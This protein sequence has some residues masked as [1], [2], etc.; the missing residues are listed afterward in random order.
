MKMNS[1]PSAILLPAQ[2]LPN[3]PWIKFAQAPHQRK[4]TGMLKPNQAACEPPYCQKE[5]RAA[6]VFSRHA[7]GLTHVCLERRARSRDR[8]IGFRGMKPELDGESWTS[9]GTVPMLALKS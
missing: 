1:E 3:R 4:E 2:L 6:L 5:I 7:Y 9:R 8:P